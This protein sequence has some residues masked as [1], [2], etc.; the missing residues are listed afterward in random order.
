MERAPEMPEQSSLARD[1]Q[2]AGLFIRS[3]R[4]THQGECSLTGLDE[5]TGRHLIVA[6][7]L[8][9]KKDKTVLYRR[10]W[11]RL[12]GTGTEYSIKWFVVSYLVGQ[13]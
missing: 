1:W 5:G 3:A 7:F 12:T 2:A 6:A 9:L 8:A 13:T 4:S 10:W 11:K